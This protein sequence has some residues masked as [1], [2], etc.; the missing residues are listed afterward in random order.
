MKPVISKLLLPVALFVSSPLC[1]ADELT[2]SE[3]EKLAK[4]LEELLHRSQETLTQRQATA[5]K[6]Y[7]SALQSETAAMELY[8]KCVELTDFEDQGKKNSDFRDW[9]RKEKDRYS[10]P[11]F[12]CALRHQLN[13]LVLT[14]EAARAG[15][16]V[17]ELAPKART[18][19]QNILADAEQLK[20]KEG[21]LRQSATDSVF[22]R[23]YGFGS[24]KVKNWPMSPLAI[25]D[26]YDKLILPPL[27]DEKKASSVRSAWMERISY[28]EKALQEWAPVPKDT[29]IGMKKDMLPPAYEKFVSEQKPKLIWQMEKDV[30]AAG[31]QAGA[32]TRMLSHISS[33][34]AHNDAIK[35]AEELQKLLSPEK[36]STV[37]KESSDPDS[38]REP[39]STSGYLELPVE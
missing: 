15:D 32:A 3:R 22:A 27:R 35:W 21:I 30:F 1:S 23:A 6:A 11:S 9:K 13:W 25:A 34:I 36:S 38:T 37:D 26:I 8:L 20:G 12:R 33:N 2:S 4:Q 18:A 31:D 17:S 10:D 39:E 19:L 29:S 5:Y 28:E 16:D 14:I 7:K 24:L